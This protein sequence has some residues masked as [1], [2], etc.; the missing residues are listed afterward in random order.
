MILE[1]III[2]LYEDDLYKDIRPINN[3]INNYIEVK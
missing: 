2:N 1:F 3:I